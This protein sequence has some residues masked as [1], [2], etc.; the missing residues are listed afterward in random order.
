MES[1]TKQVPQLEKIVADKNFRLENHR[2]YTIT[3]AENN[4]ICTIYPGIPRIDFDDK[5]EVDADV[6]EDT[7]DSWRNVFFG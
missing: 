3:T 7:R 1:L 2:A 6:H 4:L 5:Y